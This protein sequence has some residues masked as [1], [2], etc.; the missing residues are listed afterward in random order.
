M[1][2]LPATVERYDDRS[3]LL[4]WLSAALVVV[5]WALGHSIDWFPKGDPR[6]AARGVHIL[7][8]ASLAGVLVIRL[9]WRLRGG[10]RLAPTGT[11]WLDAAATYLH[12]LLY[13]LLIVT[14]ALGVCNAW[15]RGDTI[16][17]LL[18]LR[19]FDPGNKELRGTIEDA[20]ALAANI[21]FGLAALHAVAGL[22]HHLI[23]KDTVLQRML[24]GPARR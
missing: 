20:H 3:I 2:T 18:T 9:G 13:L 5:L 16:F 10:T 11:S 21:L 1:N 6:V 15:L 17:H 12:K 7:L 24:P 4:H 23:F 19:S 8:G 22:A 14:V